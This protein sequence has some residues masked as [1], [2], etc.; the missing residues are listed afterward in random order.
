[1]TGT[2]VDWR[3]SSET[4]LRQAWALIVLALAKIVAHGHAVVEYEAVAA[5][6]SLCFLRHLFEV[7][8]DARP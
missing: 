6:Q 4:G 3:S 7:L 1:M 2:C 8:E 5:P